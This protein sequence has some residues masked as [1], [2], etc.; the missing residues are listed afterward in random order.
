[1][2]DSTFSSLMNITSKKRKN[3]LFKNN[4]EDITTVTYI[5]LYFTL[6]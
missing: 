2:N 4:I 5:S 3:L 6:F 1:M